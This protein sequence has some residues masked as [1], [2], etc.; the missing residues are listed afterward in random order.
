MD[1]QSPRR[2]LD[3]AGLLFEA[4]HQAQALALTMRRHE[5]EPSLGVCKGCGRTPAGVLPVF[6]PRCA[7]AIEQ[8]RVTRQAMKRL[9]GTEPDGD[10]GSGRAVGRSPVPPEER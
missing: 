7:V 9:L 8:W 2:W 4:G 5:I 3:S 6:G 10:G 1:G